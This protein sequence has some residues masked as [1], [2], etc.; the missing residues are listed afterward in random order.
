MFQQNVCYI[1]NNIVFTKEKILFS[2]ILLFA[3]L[4]VFWYKTVTRI[5]APNGQ[6][7]LCD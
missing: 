5:L 7:T 4:A 1:N 6:N 3:A 2:A